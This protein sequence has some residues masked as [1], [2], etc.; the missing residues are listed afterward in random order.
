M[1][2]T[3][4]ELESQVDQ[5]TVETEDKEYFSY[6][7][8]G[9]YMERERKNLIDKRGSKSGKFSYY[10]FGRHYL[11][12]VSK[13]TLKMNDM[14]SGNDISGII[15]Y[16]EDMIRL[17]YKYLTLNQLK[18]RVSKFLSEL[19][20]K[21]F[22]INELEYKSTLLKKKVKKK[23]TKDLDDLMAEMGEFPGVMGSKSAVKKSK[24]LVR[25]E[26]VA[27]REDYND[28]KMEALLES[29]RAMIGKNSHALPV[30]INESRE[31]F[32]GQFSLENKAVQEL[33]INK[34]G[35]V[36]E[37]TTDEFYAWLTKFHG[38]KFPKA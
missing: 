38:S 31:Q 18:R 1:L 11:T 12:M 9:F 20:A 4:N 8:G 35:R 29:G 33:F 15:Y 22:S 28:K 19:E 10:E 37:L 17:H 36:A 5:E 32:L 7:T 6:H 13:N 16:A 21:G 3:Q 23:K 26:T 24:K 25:A 30:R 2:D 27:N 14:A 34:Q